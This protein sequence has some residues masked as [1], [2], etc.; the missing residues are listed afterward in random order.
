MPYTPS[1]IFDGDLTAITQDGP[2]WFTL[3][4]EDVGDTQSFEF[5]AYYTQRAEYFTGLKNTTSY[6]P[7]FVPSIELM[8]SIST[9]RGT[10]YLVHED[11]PQEVNNTGLLRFKR[12]WASIPIT[13]YEGTDLVYSRQFLSIGAEYSWT[14]PP[15]LP[16]V[17]EWPVPLKG[18][19][20][21]EYFLDVYPDILY[22]PR[23]NVMFGTVLY[24]P[25]SASFPPDYSQPFI[26]QDSKIR[27]YKGGIVERMT[28]YGKWPTTST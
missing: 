25:N 16:E 12:T 7:G 14:T 6:Y 23:V 2:G 28:L 8:Q 20:K 3:P 15:P 17:G 18:Y 26:A 11:E 13:R 1:R 9:A 5:H 10:A 27:I 21:Y 24:I 4:F 19:R 22:A